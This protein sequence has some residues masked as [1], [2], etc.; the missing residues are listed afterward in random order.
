VD[1]RS[2]RTLP[3]K[4]EL[5]GRLDTGSSS[6]RTNRKQGDACDIDAPS[7]RLV[8]G[9]GQSDMYMCWLQTMLL[10]ISRSRE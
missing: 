8:F 5:G 7:G 2:V 3:A 10:E 6:G 9:G 1:G 4:F